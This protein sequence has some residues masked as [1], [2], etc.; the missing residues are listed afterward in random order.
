MSNVRARVI[1][2]PHVA[3]FTELSPGCVSRVEAVSDRNQRKLDISGVA[4]KNAHLQTNNFSKRLHASK[5]S[6]LTEDLD[7][8]LV[9]TTEY[10]RLR[11]L[12]LPATNLRALSCL[13]SFY[14][15]FI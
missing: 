2:P 9:R 7:I 6:S 15:E 12:G 8:L 10:V 14:I 1:A 4:C 11:Q 3:A 13:T 5:L